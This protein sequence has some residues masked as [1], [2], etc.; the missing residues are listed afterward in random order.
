[1]KKGIRVLYLSR[2]MTIRQ[3]PLSLE[4]VHPGPYADYSDSNAY[5]TVL[6]V[7]YRDFTAVLTG[8][9]EG[10][11]EQDLVD[12]LG[13]QRL[14]AD[15]LKV[16]HHGSAGGTSQEFLHRVG[17]RTALISCGQDNPYGHPSPETVSRLKKAGMKVYDTRTT[18]QISI[19]TDG[20][21]GYTVE[22]FCR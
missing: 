22:T 20:K 15:I 3:G 17:A 19:L 16:A 8:D 2:G 5:S 10:D 13:Q 12:Y 14:E 1:M 9:L 6:L 7:R 18:G 11:G 4:C 21:S